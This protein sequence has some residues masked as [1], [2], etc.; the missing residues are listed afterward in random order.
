MKLFGNFNERRKRMSKTNQNELKITDAQW[1]GQNLLTCNIQFEARN[2]PDVRVVAAPPFREPQVFLPAG[3]AL[4][5]KQQAR[6]ETAVLSYYYD[7]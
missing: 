3:I 6:I 5:K 1:G 4:G 2:I 7:I